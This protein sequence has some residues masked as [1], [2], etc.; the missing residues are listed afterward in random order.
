MAAQQA[1]A[2]ARDKA[3]RVVPSFTMPQGISAMVAYSSATAATDIDVLARSMTSAL[4]FVTSC[5]VT[6]ATRDVEFDGLTVRRG[7]YIGLLNG[8]LA[9]ANDDLAD[10]V[11]DL[12][13]CAGAAERELVTLYYGDGLTRSRVETLVEQLAAEFSDQ[14][15]EIVQGDQPLYPYIIS[16]E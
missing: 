14:D 5:E 15:F 4:E 11:R 7:Q 3:V 2:L 6:I 10:L 9:A 8:S 13:V 12:L 1:A 16:L